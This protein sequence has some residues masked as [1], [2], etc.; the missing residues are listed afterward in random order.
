MCPMLRYSSLV[1][2][3][4]YADWSGAR[5][6]VYGTIRNYS[7]VSVILRNDRGVQSDIA[8]DPFCSGRLLMWV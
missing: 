6:S 8:Q 4:G 7:I 5:Q 1:K 3:S 2:V